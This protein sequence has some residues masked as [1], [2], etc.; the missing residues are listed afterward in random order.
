[1][2]RDGIFF[3]DSHIRLLDVSDG[4]SNTLLLGERY[5]VPRL[6]RRYGGIRQVFPPSSSCGATLP[7]Q[8]GSADSRTVI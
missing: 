2:T 4:S 1:M 3:I 7:P 6:R 8:S 5:Q